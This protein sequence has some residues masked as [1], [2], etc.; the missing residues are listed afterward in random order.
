MN[1][2]RRSGCLILRLFNLSMCDYITIRR[3]SQYYG[4]TKKRYYYC[5]RAL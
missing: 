4:I 1:G 2:W 3:K 5:G